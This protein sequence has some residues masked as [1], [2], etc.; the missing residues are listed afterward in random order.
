MYCLAADSRL[1]Q[2]SWCALSI[3][4]FNAPEVAISQRIHLWE[5]KSASNQPC[6]SSNALLDCC[7]QET[8]VVLALWGRADVVTAGTFLENVCPAVGCPGRN[9]R[10]SSPGWCR[11]SIGEMR[12]WMFPLGHTT[13]QCC[14]MLPRVQ[15]L[16]VRRCFVV[17]P[18][19]MLAVEITNTQTGVWERRDGRWCES[20]VWRFVEVNDLIS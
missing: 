1:S 6:E 17:T 14:C 3:S 8:W 9:S 16:T 13:V 18:V 11:R 7:G 15:A 12:N 10:R 19:D 4:I 5:G 20:W 2:K